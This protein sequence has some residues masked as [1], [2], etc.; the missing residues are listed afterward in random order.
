[1]Y[2]RV[3]DGS[4]N[5][6]PSARVSLFGLRSYAFHTLSE[7]IDGDGVAAPLEA[8]TDEHGHFEVA[9]VPTYGNAYLLTVRAKGV[10]LFERYEPWINRPSH[11]CGD[12]VMQKGCVV[13][14]QVIDESRGRVGNA[15]IRW[16]KDDSNEWTRN[17][18][19]EVLGQAKADGSF[20]FGGLPSRAIR[21]AADSDGL[22]SDWSAPVVLSPAAASSDVDILVRA[23]MPVRGRVLDKE[24][25]Q[26]LQATIILTSDGSNRP[27][28]ATSGPDGQ[29]ATWGALPS[30]LLGFGAYVPGYLV[31]NGINAIHIGPPGSA[32]PELSIEVAKQPALD[33]DVQDAT[34][35][36][37]L[38]GA[39]LACIPEPNGENLA[40]GRLPMF[41]ATC[42]TIATADRSG[43][44]HLAF[45]SGVHQAVVRAEGFAPRS[46]TTWELT[47]PN[48]M[49]ALDH[50]GALR[51]HV[52]GSGTPCANAQVE[53]LHAPTPR[54]D[55][56]SELGMPDSLR[57]VVAVRV[58]DDRGD[59]AFLSLP[60]AEYSVRVSSRDRTSET[61]EARVVAGQ[62]C[63]VV[64]S[65]VIACSVSGTVSRNGLAHGGAVVEA[66]ADQEHIY[67][68]M[69]DSAGAYAFDALPP[70]TYELVTLAAPSL[71]TGWVSRENSS[72]AIT[73]SNGE[74]QAVYIEEARTV[75]ISG[76][77]RVNEEP[78]AGLSVRFKLARAPNNHRPSPEMRCYTDQR[79]SY[80]LDVP[81]ESNGS[82]SVAD[83]PDGLMANELA[84]LKNISLSSAGE[85]RD[86]DIDAGTLEV[87]A[88]QKVSGKPMPGVSL[89]LRANRD[90]G[91]V[92]GCD[93]SWSCS[94]GI[95]WRRSARLLPAGNYLIEESGGTTDGPG[96]LA[97]FAIARA[98]VSRVHVELDRGQ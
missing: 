68:T 5:P 84:V 74:H 82:L 6:I 21:L 88:V 64:L 81:A 46:V 27:F 24:T 61:R 51:V 52:V 35:G 26:G 11:D 42:P 22:R 1:V 91:G 92:P 75:T 45:L 20:V 32:V 40:L 89:R 76:R 30:T 48:A 16:M 79:G 80:S 55:Y 73:L 87:E 65:A 66:R 13:S 43:R 9:A 54:G 70:G 44:I 90:Q 93:A 58:S 12:I 60:A 23:C 33:F 4:G 95:G 14:G 59:A 77:V 85:S 31:N 2:G 96:T 34:T 3:I 83:A 28:V 38:A 67:G 8:A 97:T 56:K 18:R 53:L 94:T 25:K 78:I 15:A 19:G 7:A 86:F 47:R 57:P 50:G 17:N 69:T 29:F 37:P 49:V 62:E 36:E 10:P 72:R 39:E 41:A 63:E 98:T 71:S